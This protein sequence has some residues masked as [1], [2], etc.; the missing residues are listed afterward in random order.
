M[1]YKIELKTITNDTKN[2]MPTLNKVKQYIDDY[3]D[4]NNGVIVYHTSFY[5]YRYDTRIAYYDHVDSHGIIGH[6]VSSMIEDEKLYIVA[7]INENFVPEGQFICAYRAIMDSSVESNDIDFDQFHL[8][9]IDL[10]HIAEDES[11]TI[12]KLS[13]VEFYEE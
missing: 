11:M 2:R 3:A 10:I 6:V 5:E 1:L 9:A 4:G 13:N 8:F 7:D 12:E